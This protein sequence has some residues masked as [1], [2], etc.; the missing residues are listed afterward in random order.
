M[1]IVRKDIDQNNVVL[2]LQVEKPDYTEKVEKTLRDYRKKANVPGFRPGMV[3]ASLVKK[4]YGKAVLADEINKL[5]SDEL[6][7]YIRENKVNL[8]GEPLPNEDEQNFVDFNTQESFEFSFDLGI[9]PEFE[10]ELTKKDKVNFYNITVSDEMIENQLKSYTGRYGKYIQ[11]EVVEEK[12]MVK[13][14]LLELVDGKVNE[15]GI[16]LSDAVLTPGYMKNESQKA[17]FVG[18]KKGDVVVFNPTQAFDNEAEIASLLKVSKDDVKN[19]TSDFQFQIQGI[20][21]YHESEIDQEL[22]DKVYGEGVVN[23]EEEFR[24][25]IKENIQENLVQ[26]SNYKLGTD[27]RE[28]LV[29]KYNDLTFPDAFLKRWLLATNKNITEE[30][31]EEDFSKMIAELKWQL[32]KDK[33]GKTNDIKVENEDIEAY[34]K[35]IAKAQFA[36]YGMIGLDDEMLANYAKDMLKK[37]DTV[38]GIFEKVFEGKVVEIVKNG[39]KLDNKDVTIDEFNKMFEN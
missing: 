21:R 22:F 36:Q 39:V 3:P 23:S 25:K 19:I 38:K 8:L 6:Y 24:A 30:K 35:N 37:E 11:E 13:G 14:E 2:T 33:I 9:A 34:A 27:V 28:M 31:I 20:T 29:N 12:D 18:A 1:N 26:D 4:M 32:I 5:L 17:F 10:V 7:K 16:K 15:S